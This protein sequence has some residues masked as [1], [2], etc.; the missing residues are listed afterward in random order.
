M[1]RLKS[2]EKNNNIIECDFIPEDSKESGHISVKIGTKEIE[3]YNLPSG[4]EWCRNHVEHAKNALLEMV[5]K[6]EITTEKLVMWY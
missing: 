2:I 3:S 1:V 6:E 5:S 4:Y